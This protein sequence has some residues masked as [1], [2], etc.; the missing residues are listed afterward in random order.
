MVENRRCGA[1][2]GDLSHKSFPLNR[3]LRG[4]STRAR[5]RVLLR[6]LRGQRELVLMG[7]IPGVPQDALT[8]PVPTRPGRVVF[9]PEVSTEWPLWRAPTNGGT[10][11][12]AQMPLPDTLKQRVDDW[13]RRWNQV[14]Y[15]N[16]FEWPDKTT[17][18]AF[19]DEARTLVADMQAA[20]GP[21]WQVDYGGVDY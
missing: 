5:V 9:Q 14:M 19:D 20:L 12:R 10:A 2:G 11:G 16:D 4:L 21:E 8:P 7:Q 18:A 17:R 6:L 1:V 13:A 15:D 3:L